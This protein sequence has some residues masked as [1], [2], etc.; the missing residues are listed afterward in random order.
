MENQHQGPQSIY[1][2]PITAKLNTKAARTLKRFQKRYGPSENTVYP[3]LASDNPALTHRIGLKEVH[4]RAEGEPLDYIKAVFIGTIRM[5]YGHYRIGMALASAAHSMGY[6]PYWFDLLGFDSAGARMIR[7]ADKWYSLGSRLS[8]KSK[9]FNKLLWDPLMGKWYKPLVKNYPIMEATAI[10]ADVHKEIPPE[11]PF[12][13]T[14]P[15]NAQGALHAGLKRVVNVVPDNCPLGFHL[16]PGALHTV[17]SPSAYFSF[18]TL[19]DLGAREPG[20]QGIPENQVFLTGHYV[21]HELTSNIDVD[22]D[23]RLRRMASGA[24]R[25]LLISIGGA[26]AQQDLLIALLN[27]LMPRLEQGEVAL[28]LNCGDHKVALDRMVA[29]VSGFSTIARMHTDW[30]ETQCQIEDADV[31]LAGGLHVFLHEN[32]FVAVYT[33]NM[34]M[35]VAD[36]LITKPSELAFYPIPKL[37]LERVGGHEA[38]GAIRAAELGDGTAEC[39]G[40]NQI[41]QAMELLLNEDDL[42]TLY[43][44]QIKRLKTLGVYDGAYNA[45]KLAVAGAME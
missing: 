18:R 41:W 40:Q 36:I 34:L 1:G 6:I 20:R 21:D 32:P 2:I 14:H 43:C 13:G 3:L 38:W 25:R 33:T 4:A 31:S 10:F 7:D 24:P 8:Q 16:A 39:R 5:G 37:L 17:Q 11:T 23:A 35:R 45:V 19:R 42:L 12:L 44:A 22:C 15:F 9:I 28:Y 27:R 29:G 30:D 26:G